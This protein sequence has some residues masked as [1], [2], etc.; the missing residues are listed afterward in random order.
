MII[1]DDENLVLA[2]STAS[3]DDLNA[4][5]RTGRFPY[6]WR[7][8]KFDQLLEQDFETL[9]LNQDIG[10]WQHSTVYKS[11]KIWVAGCGTNQAIFTALKFPNATVLGSDLSDESLEICSQT[12][13]LLGISNLQLKRESLNQVTYKEQ[14][15]YIICTGV[16]HHN[17]NPQTT[18]NKLAAA[19]KQQGILEL[20][21]YNR[22]H[23]LVNSTFQK[24]V[25][26]ISESTKSSVNF[27]SELSIAM[28]IVNG[29]FSTKSLMAS[30]L[31]E[32]RDGSEAKL[33]DALIQPVEHSYT[34]ESLEELTTC[35]GLE[36][37]APRINMFDVT[38]NAFSWN[39]EFNDPELQERYDSLPDSRRW[40]VSNLLLLEESP[41][42]W[43]YVQRI[44][45]ERQRKSE[46]HICEEFLQSRFERNSTTQKSYILG[47]DGKYKQSSKPIKF[48][49]PSS[50][51]LSRKILDTIDD[52][53]FMGEI[54]ER[55]GN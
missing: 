16:I 52:K 24:A 47:S 34:V 55:L 10:D 12:A 40:Q 53:S 18:L 22:F 6:P 1:S 41:M 37:V 14:F 21:V 43:F 11:P 42:I 38:R 3:V 36:L 23:R 5:F 48:P 49:I 9:M 33:A 30:F 26:I 29:G 39:M 8:I 28:K 19:L 17:A 46:R 27:E 51:P 4:K 2:T 15:D 25:R 44:D 35:C 50:D 31:S 54:F 7:P 45:C 32:Y 20:M 13:D